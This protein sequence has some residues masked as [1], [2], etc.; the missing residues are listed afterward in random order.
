MPPKNMPFW[1]YLTDTQWCTQ[2]ERAMRPS[3][4][5]KDAWWHSRDHQDTAFRIQR[6]MNRC[7]WRGHQRDRPASCQVGDGR[8]NRIHVAGKMNQT[9][10]VFRK[11]RENKCEY[12]KAHYKERKRIITLPKCAYWCMRM[13]RESRKKLY[14]SLA[15]SFSYL[16]PNYFFG[17]L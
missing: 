3:L 12:L 2:R 17:L 1:T 8:R 10:G 13:F 9:G 14:I 11:N 15:L 5:W 7:N 4:H 16:I 6:R